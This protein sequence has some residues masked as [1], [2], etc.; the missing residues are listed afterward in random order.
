[1]SDDEFIPFIEKKK[2]S[3]FSFSPL[4]FIKTKTQKTLNTEIIDLYNELKPKSQD[5]YIREWIIKKFVSV[6]G[7]LREYGS[8]STGTFLPTSDLDLVIFDE[9]TCPDLDTAYKL[10]NEN[11]LV[12]SIINLRNAK[13]PVLRCTDAFFGIRI[14]IASSLHGGIEQSVFTKYILE[15]DRALKIFCFI[16]KK[17]LKIRHLTDSRRGGLCSYAQFLLAYHFFQMHPFIQSGLINPIENLDILFLD[18]FQFYGITFNYSQI[19]VKKTVYYPN[20]TDHML[21][22]IDPTNVDA[23]EKCSNMKGIKEVFAHAYK[24]MKLALMEQNHS[25]LQ[26][27]IPPDDSDIR[28]RESILKKAKFIFKD[29]ETPKI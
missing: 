9:K 12:S 23:G 16:L 11:N 3:Y 24:I 29:N 2:K 21:S 19:D 4:K 7:E 13:I 15:G 14:D 22:V 5:I 1:M 25:L 6:L 27:W 26:L 28:F 20:N 10:L 8:F 17:F 18:F